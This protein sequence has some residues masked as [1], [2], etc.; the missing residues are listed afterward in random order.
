MRVRFEDGEFQNALGAV[1]TDLS[2]S[3]AKVASSAAA[4]LVAGVVTRKSNGSCA[5]SATR[6]G[7]SPV[8]FRINSSGVPVTPTGM[9]PTTSVSATR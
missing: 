8:F 5:S 4:S 1:A 7:G 2:T 9:Q 3:A 6:S